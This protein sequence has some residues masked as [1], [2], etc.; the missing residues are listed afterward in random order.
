MWV[1]SVWFVRAE[2]DLVDVGGILEQVASRALCRVAP[3]AVFLCFVPD[4]TRWAFGLEVNARK[5]VVVDVTPDWVA[6]HAVATFH[7]E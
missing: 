2:C 4:E 5:A 3:V 7:A 1:L 6:V